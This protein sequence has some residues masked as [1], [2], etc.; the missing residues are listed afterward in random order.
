MEIKE[1]MYLRHSGLEGEYP[2]IQ[3]ITRLETPGRCGGKYKVFTDKCGDWFIDS[4]YIEL[5]KSRYSFNIL[6][7]IEPCD[8]VNG[9]WIEKNTGEYLETLEVD[10]EA[11]SLGSMRFIRI[12]PKDIYEILTHEQYTGNVYTIKK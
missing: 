4:D 9:M 11:S 3:K 6:D 10:Y 5:D 8:I 7:L 2:I 1:G 12:Y